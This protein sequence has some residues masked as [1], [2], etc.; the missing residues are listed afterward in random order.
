MAYEKQTWQTGDVIT[1]EKLNH[2]E[3]GIA[4]AGG[5]IM[6][7]H[8]SGVPKDSTSITADKTRGEIMQAL[9]ENK[10]VLGFIKIDSGDNPI[11][12]QCGFVSFNTGLLLVNFP[13]GPTF[14]NGSSEPDSST[15]WTDFDQAQS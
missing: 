9:N 2:M 11:A 4:E 8:F 14:R 5:G 6:V 13:S 7:V 15:S 1:Q 12:R 10:I 3:D